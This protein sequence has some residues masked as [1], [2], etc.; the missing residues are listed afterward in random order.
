MI[1]RDVNPAK[2]PGCGA[3]EEWASATEILYACGSTSHDGGTSIALGDCQGLDCLRRQLVTERQRVDSLGRKC[4]AEKRRGDELPDDL[5][6]TTSQRDSV[7]SH[8]NYLERLLNGG[9]LA[10]VEKERDEA[11]LER[12][13]DRRTKVELFD[14]LWS[15]VYPGKTDWEYPGMVYRHVKA[16]VDELKAKVAVLEAKGE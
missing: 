16:L 8:R 6:I 3:V 4:E 5:D 15:L 10:A 12:D 1:E 14:K 11:I 2:C 9:Q 7:V 13:D